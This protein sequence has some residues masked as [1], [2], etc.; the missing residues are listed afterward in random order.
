M[1]FKRVSAEWLNQQDEKLFKPTQLLFQ[2][3]SPNLHLRCVES[4]RSAY[5]KVK[6]KK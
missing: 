1:A 2:D 4:L 3:C 6:G 5:L